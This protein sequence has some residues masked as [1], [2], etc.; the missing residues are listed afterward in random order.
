VVPL[1]QPRPLTQPE[2]AVLH[3]LVASVD[4]P[5]LRAQVDEAEVVG[6]CACG[7][8]SIELRT[9]AAKVPGEELRAVADIRR[10]VDDAVIRRWF[11]ADGRVV[12]VNLHV[13]AGEVEELEV[14]SGWDGGEIVT[15][16][17]GPDELRAGDPPD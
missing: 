6:Q 2:L 10:P 9:R 13:V 3:R 12:D 15:A 11:E 7:C 17:P 14:W 8:P 16:L 4:S 5:G 1:D